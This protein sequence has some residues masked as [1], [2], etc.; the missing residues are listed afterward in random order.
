[1]LNSLRLR[2]RIQ[3]NDGFSKFRSALVVLTV[4]IASDLHDSVYS[5]KHS[6]RKFNSV[7]LSQ[8]MHRPRTSSRQATRQRPAAEQV[9]SLS[10]RFFC[11]A[12]RCWVGSALYCLTSTGPRQRIAATNWS[13]RGA[14]P[15]APAQVGSRQKLRQ[16]RQRRRACLGPARCAPGAPRST[17]P[18]IPSGSGV[19]GRGCACKRRPRALRAAALSKGCLAV[20]C[21]GR[22]LRDSLPCSVHL[23]SFFRLPLTPPPS[24]PSGVA[25]G[26]GGPPYMRW[27]VVEAQ[28]DASLS[29]PLSSLSRSTMQ[30]PPRRGAARR[31]TLFLSPALLSLTSPV[32]IPPPR[33]APT[34][35]S[36]FSTPRMRRCA[37]SDSGPALSHLSSLTSPVSLPSPRCLAGRGGVRRPIPKVKPQIAKNR[38]WDR[39]RP[40]RVWPL[41]RWLP[42]GRSLPPL[43]R[44]GRRSPS[45]R[46]DGSGRL[47]SESAGHGRPCLRGPRVAPA[48][49][50]VR[51]CAAR[52]RDESVMRASKR[53]RVRAS[54]RA[55][56]RDASVGAWER[57]CVRACVRARARARARVIA[58]ERDASERARVRARVRAC[59]HACV[60]AWGRASA[61][62]SMRPPAI[63]RADS[64]GHA[65]ARQRPPSG[66]HARA[67]RPP[68]ACVAY[69]APSFLSASK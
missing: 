35:F 44:E 29:P 26:V 8:E 11:A 61:R 7:L 52:W 69:V 41:R 39:A 50:G 62:A 3:S 15:V 21:A 51:R 48:G 56:E 64:G 12:S 66:G 24:S 30:W 27:R 28:C 25:Q 22:R 14:A 17:Q 4:P 2:E 46:P 5:Q 68:R 57:A 20:S 59:V 53:A 9:A 65:R 55:C 67:Q 47:E 32:S 43:P 60:R 10:V 38:L 13:A 23:L 42:L 34:P 19:D 33:S 37:A 1:M 58:C 18:L 36:P 49:G 40:G 31:G 16:R 63:S 45:T 54:V 6:L